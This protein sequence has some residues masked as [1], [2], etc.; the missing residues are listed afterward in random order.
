M[1]ATADDFLKINYAMMRPKT[2]TAAAP[3]ATEAA[4]SAIVRKDQ[5]KGRKL[6]G[7]L[8][9]YEICKHAPAEHVCA[10]IWNMVCC[11]CQLGSYTL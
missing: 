5:S 3:A 10:F 6:A 9:D 11:G 2:M 7:L 4:S 8:K 1:P